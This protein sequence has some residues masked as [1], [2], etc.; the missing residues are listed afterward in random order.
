MLFSEGVIDVCYS[1][2]NTTLLNR[3]VSHFS[4]DCFDV[5]IDFTFFGD[6]ANNGP[7]PECK[8]ANCLL[9]D[10][11][12]SGPIFQTEAARS[13]RRSGLLSKIARPCEVILIVDHQPP[14]NVTQEKVANG[15]RY[16][17]TAP[18]RGLQSS[19]R[20]IAPEKWRA[21]E[22]T[23]TCVF[24]E[25]DMGIGGYAGTEDNNWLGLPEILLSNNAR[26]YNSLYS[27]C[28]RYNFGKVVSGFWKL[29]QDIFGPA[30]KSARAFGLLSVLI[31]AICLA[32]I[33]ASAC[34]AYQKCFWTCMT[35]LLTFCGLSALLTLTFFA[36]GVCENGCEIRVAAIIA[37]VAGVLWFCAAAFAFLTGP[38]D[39][40][41]PRAKTCCMPE[42]VGD[43][44][45]YP[46]AYKSVPTSE[47]ERTDV[48][49]TETV[50]SDG[51]VVV[52]KLT[53][54][55]NGKKTLE[56]TTK[57]KGETA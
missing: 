41:Q 36:S 4:I 8:I 25:E 37:I 54:F 17:Q 56:V 33:W 14:C 6:G 35:A 31:G 55:P 1:S 52:E 53:T 38:F 24:I 42:I 45:A 15:A 43:T 2:V 16:L 13:R 21:P 28:I 30:Y 44:G 57:T 22:P 39:P 11:Q 46:G 3:N 49:V 29:Q 40:N 51:S 9:C 48:S 32:F 18:S 19:E 26:I 47:P 23:E 7:P 5:C 20:P 10:E 12:M 34:V 27:T 50:Q